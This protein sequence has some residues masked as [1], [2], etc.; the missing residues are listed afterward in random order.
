MSIVE[1][2]LPP[3]ERSVAELTAILGDPSAD[4]RKA[5][6][7]I[8]TDPALTAQVLRMCNSPLFG[9][10]SRVISIEQATV[11]LGSERIRSLAMTTSFANFSER[12]LSRDQIGNFWRHSVLAAMLSKHLAEHTGYPEFEQAYIAGLLHDVGEVPQWM[13]MVEEQIKPEDDFEDRWLDNP[14]IQRR[15][16]GIDHCELGSHMARGWELMPSFVD[17]ILKHHEPLEAEHDPYL[18]QIVAG[19]EHFLLAREECLIAPKGPERQTSGTRWSTTRSRQPFDN[20]DWEHIADNLEREYDRLL[21][22]LPV[23]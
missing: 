3:F 19:V 18:V 9:R 6:G 5:A 23:L 12:G 16:F 17:V 7:P 22:L 8:R 2:G 11:L 4:I 14:M 21:P 15:H 10:H 1:N 13:L 20:V